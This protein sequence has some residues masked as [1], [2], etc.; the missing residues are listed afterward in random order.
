[1]DHLLHSSI[2][3]TSSPAASMK[4][5]SS[6]DLSELVRKVTQNVSEIMEQKFSKLTDTLDKIAG[7][8]EGHAK[9]ITEAEQQVS[10]MEDHV[11]TLKLRLSK[12]EDRQVTM[13]ELIDDAEN[14]SRR[15]NIRIL[16]LKK[17]TEGENPQ[18]FF[19]SW[20]PTLLSLS[21]AKG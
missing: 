18:E 10:A 5:A 9:R 13:A 3:A 19:E 2:A 12:V 4:G 17:G 14:R 16:N 6:M 8:L 15:D 1:M 11:A 20:L 7:S 21:A